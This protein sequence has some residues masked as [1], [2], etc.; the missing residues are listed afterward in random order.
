MVESGERQS[1]DTKRCSMS[2]AVADRHEGVAVA[3]VVVEAD[4]GEDREVRAH[5]RSGRGHLD[6]ADVGRCCGGRCAARPTRRPRPAGP[7]VAPRRR[8]APHRRR[9]T[10]RWRRDRGAA[11]GPASRARRPRRTPRRA[12]RAGTRRPT[13]CRGRASRGCAR[14][15]PAPRAP[16]GHGAY[17]LLDAAGP[18]PLDVMRAPTRCRSYHPN[19]R[20]EVGGPR[21][22]GD[23]RLAGVEERVHRRHVGRARRHLPRHRLVRRAGRRPHRGG[24]QL[25]HRRRSERL[26]RERRRVVGRPARD[27]DRPRCGCSPTRC[28]RSTTARCR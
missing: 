9:G 13:S 26:G 16:C 11:P 1:V 22:D 8:P 21:H 28:S 18:K 2:H 24:R 7:P 25:L 15:P 23:A 20:V 6:E 19:I 10:R 3:A 5:A 12:G 27:D 17:A 14:G 4:L